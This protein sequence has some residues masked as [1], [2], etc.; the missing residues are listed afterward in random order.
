MRNLEISSFELSDISSLQ[1]LILVLKIDQEVN[2]LKVFNDQKESIP[3]Y[4][5]KEMF[6][7]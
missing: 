3:T 1:I 4:E 5:M 7:L 2:S 6:D